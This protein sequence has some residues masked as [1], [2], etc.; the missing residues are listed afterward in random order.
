[1]NV[2]ER[3]VELARIER[4]ETPVISV[5]LN[6]HWAD[7]HQRDRV[8]VF[9]KNELAQARR[10]SSGRAAEADLDWIEREGEELVAQSRFPDAHGV[11]LFA[12]QAL[13]LREVLPVRVAFPDSFVVADAPFLRPL[14][15]M[16]K[17]SP[18]TVVVFVSTESARLIPL[19]MEGAGEEVVL[20]SDVASR[21]SPLGWIRLAQTQYQQYIRN[22]RARHFE[23]VIE[24]LVALSERHGVER[25]VL[26]GEAK[27][28][29]QFRQMLPRRMGDLVAG[30]VA[31]TRDESASLIGGRATALVTH[32]E[33]QEHAIAI[34]TVLTEAAKG[35]Q[36]VASLDETLEA[37]NRGAVRCLY[38]LSGFSHAGRL[39]LGCA[40]L[41]R[42][43]DLIC[44][45]CGNEAKPVELANALVDRV[46]ASG[47]EVES[48]DV[49]EALGR[50]GGVA[51]LLR[52][53]L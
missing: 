24:S 14:A 44:R 28:V 2:R 32:L 17:E 40:S 9:L 26:A 43:P 5:Y 29:A 33:G 49:H 3:M 48:L 47:G 7:E 30:V 46:I 19:T 6:T 21:H 27:H 39:C 10:A 37:V 52:Y 4:A 23:A 34:D 20:E 8:R 38:L 35:G 41:Q 12:C 15:A 1:M 42:G 36:A 51:A 18:S 25:I 50:V 13:H 53:P 22:H 11:A 16:L 31:G 45:L